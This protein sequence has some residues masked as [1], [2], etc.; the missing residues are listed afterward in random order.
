MKIPRLTGSRSQ[1]HMLATLASIEPMIVAR[2]VQMRYCG[3][4]L[5]A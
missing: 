4:I 2:V 3:K 5:I 1:A